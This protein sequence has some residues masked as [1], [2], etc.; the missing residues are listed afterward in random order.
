MSAQHTPGPRLRKPGSRVQRGLVTIS[1]E[2]SVFADTKDGE[3]ADGRKEA[4]DVRAALNYI[5]AAIAKATRAA[6]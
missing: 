4:D 3:G 1:A 6:A 2:M 5:D